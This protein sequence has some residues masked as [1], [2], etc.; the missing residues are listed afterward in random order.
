MSGADP[1]EPEGDTTVRRGRGDARPAVCSLRVILGDQVSAHPVMDRGEFALGRGGDIV[2]PHVN[3][4]RRHVAVRVGDFL[5][6]SD[7]GST[8]ATTLHGSALEPNT[9]VPIR[10]GDVLVVGGEA[11]VMLH[12]GEPR[13]L[14]TRHI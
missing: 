2:I 8:N 4:S 7:L 6:V 5:E 3:I 11:L 1:N 12:D 14:P 10:P 9:W 13:S